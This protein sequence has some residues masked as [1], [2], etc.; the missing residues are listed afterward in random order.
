M[1]HAASDHTPTA[2]KF[3]RT[4]PVLLYSLNLSDPPEGLF[5]SLFAAGKQPSAC[6]Q[7]AVQ[8]RAAGP[9]SVDEETIRCGSYTTLK[10][11][12]RERGYSVEMA[13]MTLAL[14]ISASVC[15]GL[16]AAAKTE[17]HQADVFTFS[18]STWSSEQTTVSTHQSSRYHNRRLR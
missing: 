14:L 3:C 18:F 2:S 17:A 5:L 11:C 4:P 6:R 15:L 9:F 13:K 7:V 12:P 1:Y 10:L 16:H 8:P